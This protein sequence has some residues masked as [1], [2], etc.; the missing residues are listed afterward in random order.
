M[1]QDVSFC[2]NLNF[3]SKNNSK[4]IIILYNEQCNKKPKQ[5]YIK[6]SKGCNFCMK[7]T[8]IKLITLL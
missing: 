5:L 7:E 3:T 1:N 2:E 8:H 4:S 6:S